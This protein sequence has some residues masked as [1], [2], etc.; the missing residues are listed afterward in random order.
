M[1]VGRVREVE[2]GEGRESAVSAMHGHGG[3]YRSTED[4]VERSVTQL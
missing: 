2:S 3:S 4:L 1:Q